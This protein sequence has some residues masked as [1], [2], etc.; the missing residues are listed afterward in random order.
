MLKNEILITVLY[1]LIVCSGVTKLIEF[2]IAGQLA[3][4]DVDVEAPNK[5]GDNA[6]NDVSCNFSV[7]SSKRIQLD[8]STNH[9]NAPDQSPYNHRQDKRWFSFP[10]SQK[11]QGTKNHLNHF[12]N[13]QSCEY[14]SQ[15]I[16]IGIIN[17]PNDLQPLDTVPGTPDCL[18]S[19]DD[20]EDDSHSPGG[21]ATAALR[22]I[23]C[24]WDCL[25]V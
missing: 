6:D 16:C 18:D 25:T 20:G 21:T 14:C 24:C 13:H 22:H 7:D 12:G 19:P 1:G 11:D 23:S 15:A 4:V 10:Y 5:T 3:M 9:Y 8:P 17:I 2:W